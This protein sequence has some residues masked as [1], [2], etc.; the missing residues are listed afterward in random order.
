M[1]DKIAGLNRIRQSVVG[2]PEISTRISAYELAFRMQTSVP[3]LLDIHDEPQHILDMYGPDVKKP[4]TYAYNCILARRLA[5]RG[6]RFT[7]LFHMGWDQHGN[8]PSQIKAQC[9]DTDQP[10]AALLKDLKQRGLL[11]DTV[12][13]WGGE[14]GRTVYS[15]GDLTM[16]NY[17]RDHHPRCFTV[18]VAGGG[19][20]KGFA[21][22]K[23]DDYGYNIVENPVSVHDLHATM[24][25]QLGINHKDLTYRF[26]GRDFRLT[27]VFGN[28]VS[29]LL[30]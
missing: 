17:G 28:V 7:Q 15:Q 26:Q 8:L 23:T 2:D 4:G 3:G 10:S 29:D 1:L 19:F 9:M 21:Y 27:D 6:V 12:I 20:K 24:L 13:V 18:W 25:H 14:F 5:E 22:G 16:T 11:D 30:A